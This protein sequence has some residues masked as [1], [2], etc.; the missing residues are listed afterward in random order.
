MKPWQ[1]IWMDIDS[2]KYFRIRLST[3]RPDKVTEFK[4]YLQVDGHFI[5]YLRAG[6]KLSEGKISLLHGRDSG[7]SFFVRVEDREAYRQ[8]VRS[9]MNSETIN[10]LDKAKILRESALAIMEDLFENP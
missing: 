2:G 1:N 10:S 5:L 9:E 8:W 4:I 6:D 3:I 7:N